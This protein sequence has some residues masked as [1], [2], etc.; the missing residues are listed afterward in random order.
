[1][2]ILALIPVLL[3]SASCASA[4]PVTATPINSGGNAHKFFLDCGRDGKAKCI[5]KANEVCPG[6]YD[7][8]DEKEKTGVDVGLYGGGSYT[9]TTMEIQCK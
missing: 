4:P 8:T 6:G 9:Q 7:V 2:K 1:M 3:L 5:E